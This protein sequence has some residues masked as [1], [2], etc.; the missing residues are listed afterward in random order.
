MDAEMETKIAAECAKLFTVQTASVPVKVQLMAVEM[1]AKTIFLT[2][3]KAEKRLEFFDKWTRSIR[4]E[5][6]KGMHQ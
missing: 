6:K 1:L 3:I 5:L 2:S 4:G